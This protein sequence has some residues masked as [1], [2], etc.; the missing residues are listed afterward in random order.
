MPRE[1]APSLYLPWIALTGE[2]NC[3]ATQALTAS[4]WFVFHCNHHCGNK[5]CL[6]IFSFLKKKERKGKE[7]KKKRKK[8]RKRK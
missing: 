8:K 6:S 4:W 5:N 1:H 2:P 3:T 7:K